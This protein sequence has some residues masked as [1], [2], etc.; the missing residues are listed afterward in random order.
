MGQ[1]IIGIRK[2]YKERLKEHWDRLFYLHEFQ[3]FKDML[4]YIL[5]IFYQG[6]YRYKFDK[7]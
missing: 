6:Y 4:L 1:M 7:N 2:F 3:C 5:F